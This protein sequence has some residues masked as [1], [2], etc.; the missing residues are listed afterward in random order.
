[1]RAMTKSQLARAAG[2]SR[3]TLRR[4]LEE[5]YMKKQLAKFP[6]TNRYKLPGQLVKIICEHYVIDID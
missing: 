6:Q 1:M 5:P 2:V 3:W 4:W